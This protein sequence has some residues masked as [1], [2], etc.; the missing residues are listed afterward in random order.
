MRVHLLAAV[1][2]V[3]SGFYFGI[4]ANEWCVVVICIGMVLA[5]EALNSAIEHLTDMVQ[6][7]HHPLAGKIKDMA[8]AGVLIVAIAAAIAG[9]V[10]FRKYFFSIN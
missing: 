1:V 2:V 5:A 6:P 9:A 4:T 7:D 8:S 10:I 3:A